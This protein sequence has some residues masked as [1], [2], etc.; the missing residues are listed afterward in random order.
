MPGEGRPS[1]AR[2]L[3]PPVTESPLPV[4]ASP[5]GEEQDRCARGCPVTD[6]TSGATFTVPPGMSILDAA[7]EQGVDLP[8]GCRV[9]AC[10]ACMAEVTEGSENLAAPDLLEAHSLDRFDAPPRH[11]LICRA[12]TSGAC[13]IRP[14]G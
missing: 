8:H 11:R 1:P 4:A 3:P 7:I 14:L 13:T 2:R 6:A 5:P 9:G 12:M 10:G